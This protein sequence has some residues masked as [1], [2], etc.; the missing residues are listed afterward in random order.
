MKS[1][2]DF[3]GP[4]IFQLCL[5]KNRPLPV[6]GG[7]QELDINLTFQSEEGQAK[8]FSRNGPMHFEV[9]TILGM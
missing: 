8:I 5:C 3:C 2:L 7:I 4:E 1:S 9:R 6:W